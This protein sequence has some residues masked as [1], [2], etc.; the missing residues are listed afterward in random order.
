MIALRNMYRISLKDKIANS[1]VK[2]LCGM[3][4]DVVI[5]LE[6]MFDVLFMYK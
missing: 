4:D 1:V 3:K 6:G 5:L 2:E